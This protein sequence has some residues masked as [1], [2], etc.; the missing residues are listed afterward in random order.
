MDFKLFATILLWVLPWQNKV[1][2]TFYISVCYIIQQD[3][4][5]SVDYRMFR[6][7][8]DKALEHFEPQDNLDY[9]ARAASYVTS[10]F[11]ISSHLDTIALTLVQC[12]FAG[13]GQLETIT[14]KLQGL[15]PSRK[16]SEFKIESTILLR[17]F[18]DQVNMV[19][20]RINGKKKSMNLDRDRTSFTVLL[21]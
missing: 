4:Q 14:C 20:A 7:D 19:H 3:D 11:I 18:E 13:E 2:H 5:V 10:H 12:D 15:A 16:V 6:N 1:M 21:N 8:L 9:C 17:E